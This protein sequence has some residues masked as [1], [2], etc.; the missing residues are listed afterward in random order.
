MKKYILLRA[1]VIAVF[2]ILFSQLNYAADGTHIYTQNWR[3]GYAFS[4]KEWCNPYN[5][6]GYVDGLIDA[7]NYAK[8][9][10]KNTLRTE[11]YEALETYYSNYP[12]MRQRPVIDVLIE[13]YGK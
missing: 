1:V 11:A 7:L 3:N 4:D 9:L 10:R 5:Q 12:D 6:H 13:K 2:G 8:L